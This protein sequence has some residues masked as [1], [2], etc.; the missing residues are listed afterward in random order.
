VLHR[1]GAKAAQ[2][3]AIAFGHGGGYFAKDGVDDIFDVTLVEMGILG[4]N[5][6]DKL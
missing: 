1:K 6:L 3:D 5:S 4:G 2:F